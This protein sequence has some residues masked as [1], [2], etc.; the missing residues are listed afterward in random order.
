MTFD[1]YTYTGQEQSVR[2]NPG[3]YLFQL[4]GANGGN[5]QSYCGYGGFSSGII[6]IHEFATLYLFV[7]GKGVFSKNP[8]GGF[9]GG[10]NGGMSAE[11]SF[12]CGTGGGG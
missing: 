11:S 10:G 3:A 2:I 4:W 9:N 5:N 6:R 12:A 8:I 1:I 7:G